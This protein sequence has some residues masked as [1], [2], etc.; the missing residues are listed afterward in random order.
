MSHLHI[1]DGLLPLWLWG[2]SLLLAIAIL[3]WPQPPVSR[4]RV[5]YHG[6]LGGLMLA[7][8]AVPLGPIEYHLTLAAPV[9]ILLGARGSFEVS[10][11]VSAILALMGHGGLTV[12]GL[13]AM[14][15]GSCAAVASVVYRSLA[16]RLTAPWAMGWST[17]VG[18]A[19]GGALS[20]AIVWVAVRLGG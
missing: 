2:P 8:M 1:P 7:A 12:I 14:V 6:A 5:A 11:V 4:Q 18:Q 10:F 16:N 19:V 3:A 20:L 9:G 15:M 17:A 13:N